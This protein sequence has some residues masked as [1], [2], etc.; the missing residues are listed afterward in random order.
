MLNNLPLVRYLGRGLRR[1]ALLLIESVFEFLFLRSQEFV[2]FGI[3][4]LDLV[5][6]R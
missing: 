4:P 6:L 1:M 2:V 5:I 3:P